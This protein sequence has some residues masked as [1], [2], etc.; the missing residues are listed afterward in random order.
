MESQS[1]NTYKEPQLTLE[2]DLINRMEIRITK[3]Y[4]EPNPYYDNP[5]WEKSEIQQKIKELK[6]ISNGTDSSREWVFGK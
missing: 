1:Q 2:K 6:K 4:K 5:L 3:V